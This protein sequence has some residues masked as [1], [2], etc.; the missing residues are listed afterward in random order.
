[1]ATMR[2]TVAAAVAVAI[3]RST[4]DSSSEAE[5][6]YGQEQTQNPAM[7]CQEAANMA[8]DAHYHPGGLPT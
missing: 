6:E 3:S 1:M 4:G 7:E 8:M 5:L 2:V